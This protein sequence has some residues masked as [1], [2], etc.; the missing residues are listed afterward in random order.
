MVAQPM[1]LGSSQ[2]QEVPAGTKQDLGS[3]FL[4]LL[5]RARAICSAKGAVGSTSDLSAA[6]TQQLHMGTR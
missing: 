3:G 2:A 1:H 6:A 4:H 5:N